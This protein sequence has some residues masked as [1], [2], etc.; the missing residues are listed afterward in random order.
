[1]QL[2]FLAVGHRKGNAFPNSMALYINFTINKRSSLS[3][4]IIFKMLKMTFQPSF[5][6]FALKN[7]KK[8]NAQDQGA[9]KKFAVFW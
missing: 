9:A 6:T 4:V 8:N 2:R 1:L 7:E 5:F 3:I